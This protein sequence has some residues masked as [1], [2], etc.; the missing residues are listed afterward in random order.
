MAVGEVARVSASIIVPKMEAGGGEHFFTKI[1]K[2]APASFGAQFALGKSYPARLQLAQNDPYLCEETTSTN[3]TKTEREQPRY[4]GK[5]FG[6]HDPVETTTEHIVPPRDHSTVAI[7]VKRGKCSFEEK[8]RN[9]LALQPTGIIKYLIVYDNEKRDKLVPMSPSTEL[10]N[11][12]ALDIGLVFVSMET[13]KELLRLNFEQPPATRAAGGFKIYID[14]DSW[15]HS[16][17]YD[18]PKDGMIAT[19]SGFLIFVFCCGFSLLCVQAGFVHVE[20]GFIFVGNPPPEGWNPNG[21]ANDARGVRLMT[22]EEVGELETAR[23][24]EQL[25][26]CAARSDVVKGRDEDDVAEA[27][28]NNHTCAVC[29]E[30]YL[31]DERL[32]I[33]P[34]RHS[35]HAKC[36]TPWLTERSPT[37]P[38]CKMT[39]LDDDEE[40][41]EED[42]SSTVDAGLE[43][44][45]NG[46]AATVGDDGSGLRAWWRRRTGRSSGEEERNR[47]DVPMVVNDDDDDD[48][49]TGSGLGLGWW[50]R[51][52]GPTHGRADSDEDM[53]DHGTEHS[54]DLSAP[55]LD[56]SVV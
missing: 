21:N 4:V 25:L 36:I 28:F 26:K 43:E 8:A 29:L 32:I 1:F 11:H 44:D 34:C 6:P 20:N 22:A 17:I 13:G 37:C 19:L 48:D 14:P 35:F 15:P 45:G 55:L 31:P 18:N 27:R 52:L 30:D 51:L 9:A 47:R 23:Y 54:D 42:S 5:L 46:N 12:M 41:E 49:D 3:G 7:L 39:L 16:G 38:L 56:G 24:G 40:E 33:L 2:S 53:L 50:R 10:G